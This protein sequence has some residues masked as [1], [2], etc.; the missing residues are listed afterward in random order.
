MIN[1]ETLDP[2]IQ[3]FTNAN[4]ENDIRS[5]FIEDDDFQLNDFKETLKWIKYSFLYDWDISKVNLDHLE[6]FLGSQNKKMDL[7]VSFIFIY[8]YLF[9]NL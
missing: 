3:N 1:S 7:L 2:I 5:R 9:I 8:R 4:E 6:V